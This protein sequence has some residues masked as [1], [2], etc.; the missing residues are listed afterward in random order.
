ME[1]EETGT[2]LEEGAGGAGLDTG[3]RGA[4][5]EVESR[6]V[7]FEA[8]GVGSASICVKGDTVTVLTGLV[9]AEVDL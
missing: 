3:D 9:G 6:G 5:F 7:G 4:A 1:V 8:A 2:G